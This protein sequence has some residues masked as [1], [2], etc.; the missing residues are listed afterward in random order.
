MV[1]RIFPRPGAMRTWHQDPLG[2]ALA[3]QMVREQVVQQARVPATVLLTGRLERVLLLHH[4]RHQ[5]G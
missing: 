5:L 4:R 3:V 1:A 2:D